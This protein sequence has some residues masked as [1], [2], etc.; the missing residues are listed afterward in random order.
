[1]PGGP[2]LGVE[3]L[4]RQLQLLPRLGQ[5]AAADRLAVDLEPLGEAHQMRAAEEPGAEPVSAQQGFDRAARRRLAVRPGHLD[6]G[7][8]QL[9]R[10]DQ[11]GQAPNRLD[12][13]SR[14][15]LAHAR[16]QLVVDPLRG[17]FCC[18]HASS[19]STR[20]MTMA[21]GAFSAPRASVFVV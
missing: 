13:G 16:Q 12:A 10:S 1:M 5:R 2:Q 4:Q 19:V 7:E 20:V 3:H 18:G 14:M 9:R 11:L 15:G 8:G 17:L 6:D 21:S